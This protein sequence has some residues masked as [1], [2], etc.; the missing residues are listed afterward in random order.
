M[1]IETLAARVAGE[2][3]EA[4]PGL[5]AAAPGERGAIIAKTLHHSQGAGPALISA[6]M[7]DES[8][9]ELRNGWI[10]HIGGFG[11]LMQAHTV[12]HRMVDNIIV[13]KSIKSLVE[14][15]RAFAASPT[16]VTE[17]YT[18]VAGT[19]VAEVV[20]LGDDIELVPWTE[21]PDSKQKEIFSSRQP[22][23]ALMSVPLPPQAAATWLYELIR[24]NAGFY[25]HRMTTPSA[26]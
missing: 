14:D 2:V 4:E 18:P 22:D 24:R 8:F 17:S 16:A 11:M 15:A 1:D 5:A 23:Y 12:P 13:G 19:T 6:F 9:G 21:V 25:F 7:N 26:S 10:Q 3:L 20:S